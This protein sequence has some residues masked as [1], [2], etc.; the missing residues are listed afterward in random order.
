MSLNTIMG[1]NRLPAPEK[2]EIYTRLIPAQLLERMDLD[3]S[4]IDQEGR[5]LLTLKCPPDSSS[6]EMSLHHQADFEDPVLY[7]H[8]TDT[9]NGQIHILLYVLNDPHSPRFDVDRMPDGRMT[10]FGT[11]FRNLRAEQDAM[12]AGLAPGQVRRGLRLLPEAIKS[13]EY[14]IESLQHDLYFVEPLYYHN[15]L[16]FERYGFA[17]Q[18]GKQFM[19]RINA[20]FGPGGPL[21][22]RLD[23]STP[24]RQ[25]EAAN[26]IRL[27]SW[28]IQ[29]GL[30]GQTFTDVTMY[31]RIGVHSEIN[32]CPGCDW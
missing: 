29:D 22:S 18:R 6:V 7:G 25:P 31:K 24:F 14:F 11:A 9:L 27:R 28:A 20:G 17:Y 30:L 23:G 26:S 4:L 13:F 16:L 10:I 5:D 32:T 1:I 21:R 2:R 3:A 12:Q 15:A 8:M 19:E